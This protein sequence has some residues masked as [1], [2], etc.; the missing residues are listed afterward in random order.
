MTNAGAHQKEL[1]RLVTGVIRLVH[2]QRIILFGSRARG[3]DSVASDVDLLVVMDEGTHRRNTA[4]YLYEHLRGSG[5]PFDVVVA[6][7]ADLDK[8]KGNCGL[9]YQTALTEGVT[10]YDAQ[11]TSHS[12]QR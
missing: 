4:Q 9:I 5:V 12:G 6:T 8:H 2:P 7:T 11:G 3:T 1:K 10:V